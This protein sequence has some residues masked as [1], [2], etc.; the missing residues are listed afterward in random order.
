MKILRILLVV[1]GIS[2][3]LLAKMQVPALVIAPAADACGVHLSR[4]C[5]GVSAYYNHLPYAPDTGAYSCLRIHQLLYNEV[6]TI[7]RELPGGEVAVEVPNVF[8]LDKKGRK[9]HDFWMLKKNLIPLQRLS[10]TVRTAIPPVI[11]STDSRDAYS[12]D[13]LTLTAPWYDRTTN[14]IYSVGTRFVRDQEHDTVKSYAV[15]VVVPRTKKVVRA[16][17]PKKDAI[18][19]YY[20]SFHRARRV[21]MSLLRSWAHQSKG[22]IPYVYGG[23]SF[24][25]PCLL[26]G[27][28][29]V[30]SKKCALK[31]S[32]WERP[33]CTR[34]PKS[35]FDCSNMILRAAQIAG[36]PYYFKNT[37]AL[38]KFL[39]PLQKGEPLEEGDLVWYSGHVMVVSDLKKNLLIEAI[40]YDSGFGRLHEI[41]ISKAF[42]GIKTLEQ[43]RNIYFNKKFTYRLKSTGEPWRSIYQI[44]ILKLKSIKN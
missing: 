8:Y 30:V 38:K 24:T 25:R 6:V 14:Q 34:V 31:A 11:D 42:S 27:Y 9:R 32:F 21:F 35:G 15:M 3:A 37:H 22:F 12:S 39:K 19:T 2:G 1:L 26:G 5:K 23:C 18:V 28:K 17:V 44:T 20:Q 29:K 43:L 7:V 40:G 13:I 41:S 10:E 4:T 33:G 16:H 36:L